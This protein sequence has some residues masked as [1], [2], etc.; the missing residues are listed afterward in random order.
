MHFERIIVGI[1]PVNSVKMLEIYNISPSLPE[2]M[3]AR[4]HVGGIGRKLIRLMEIGFGSSMDIGGRHLFPELSG[5]TC[6]LWKLA[7]RFFLAS[8]RYRRKLRIDPL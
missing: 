4:F 8:M 3:P 2:V 7:P 1:T 5:K 6:G